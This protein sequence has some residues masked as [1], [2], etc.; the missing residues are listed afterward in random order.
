M[1]KRFVV[2]GM[3]V[4]F[5]A[6][7]VF[8]AM[9]QDPAPSQD[10]V[11]ELEKKIESLESQ[12][13]ELKGMLLEQKQTQ[14]APAATAPPA[15]PATPAAPAEVK[16]QTKLIG[17]GG[18]L[19]LGG[20]IRFRG[21]YF[22]NLWNLNNA[23]DK[24]QREVF[25][26]RPRV[27]LDW[28][29]TEDMEAYVRLTKE[30]FYGQDNERLDYYVEA[31]DVMFDNAWGEWKNMFGSPF[32]LRVGRQDLIYGDGFIILDGT[33]NDGSQTIS[34]DAVKL[35]ATHD[36]GS[37][38]LLYSKL[39]E[40]NYQSAD[41]EDLYGIYNKFKFDNVEG[42]GVEPYFLVRNKNDAPDFSG[43]TGLVDP[44]TGITYAATYPTNA[45]DPSPKEQTY[46]LGLRSTYKFDVVDGVNLALAVEGGKEW[47][48]VDFTGSPL[49]GTNVMGFNRFGGDNTVSRDAWGG[50][51]NGILTFNDVMW[52][53]SFK[54]GVSY[55]SGDDPTT[56]D[57]E[58]WDDFY[59]QW[60]K[61]SELY[62]Y[63]LYDGFKF[64]TGANDPDVGVW[65]NQ[66]IPE[67]EL[68]VKPTERLTQSL[69]FLYFLADEENGPGDGSERGQNVQW[70]TNYV[71]TKNLSGHFLFEWFNPGDY[72]GPGADDA[73]FT[74][75]QL[76]YTF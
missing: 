74:R 37:T 20:D 7:W 70:L 14:A 51:A 4:V 50:Q 56:A 59:S 54:A 31:K 44:N 34:F 25:R 22:D 30:W 28:K 57:Y 10:K 38:D 13:S 8:P 21:L 55:M 67:V 33:A 64:L 3:S 35:T 52:K 36:W 27:F 46:L 68:T 29:P 18:T 62:V 39:Y 19:Q 11:Q 15:V 17:P 45:F 16:E 43:V 49:I 58:G 2:V 1:W 53:P 23:N 60:P 72:Y 47:G 75:F 9:G 40:N 32:T 66:I 6:Y 41:D 76:M 63:T 61:Y 42:L 48:N 12:L 26:F 5:M 73:I 71:F 69:R 24:D 65:N